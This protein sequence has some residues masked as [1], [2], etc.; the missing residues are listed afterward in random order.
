VPDSTKGGKDGDRL[1]PNRLGYNAMGNA[2]D[3]KL[4]LPELAK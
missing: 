2:V 3:L 4:L 1:H